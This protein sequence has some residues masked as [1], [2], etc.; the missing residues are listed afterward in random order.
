MGA[1]GAYIILTIMGRL[2]WGIASVPTTT[3]ALR[4]SLQAIRDDAISEAV[5]ARSDACSIKGILGFGWTV[6][7]HGIKDNTGPWCRSIWW[8]IDRW[9]VP[10]N[11]D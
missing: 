1:L 3:D 9:E 5:K 4:L 6:E 10:S 7:R 11:P 2:T 8:N